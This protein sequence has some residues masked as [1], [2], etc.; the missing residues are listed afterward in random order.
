[1]SKPK[2]FKLS[3]LA[4]ITG[5][6]LVGND[7]LVDNLATIQH[8][9]K[10]S[11][12]F[13][14]NK[15]YYH[16]LSET[17]AGS[18]IVDKNSEM[19]N[20]KNFLISENPYLAFAK[21]TKLFKTS[22]NKKLP[23]IHET[24]VIDKDSFIDKNVYIGPNVFIGPNCKVGS[25][26]VINANVSIVENVSIGSNVYI[27]CGSV[28]GSDGFG[29]ASSNNGYEKIEQLGSL[30]I[31]N[32]VHIGSNCTIDRGTLDDTEIHDGVILD[33]QVHI[34]HNVVIH[35]NSAIAACC[36]I[37]GSTLIGENFQMG[38]LSGVLGHLQICNDVK[39]GAHTLITKNIN[40]PGEYI[41]IMPAQK[42]KEWAKSSIFIKNKDKK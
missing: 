5:S 18:V 33:N 24:A 20:G 16:L 39:V 22:D 1:M 21:L 12:T 27:D 11:L 8:A 40:E 9:N 23:F 7:V 36:A 25:D 19:S 37:A 14:A 17:K 3:E 4:N 29:F 6:K 42:F 30:K 32:N 28:L 10:T 2:S 38:G 41:G 34:A 35:K 31:G 15:K 26:V 13:V